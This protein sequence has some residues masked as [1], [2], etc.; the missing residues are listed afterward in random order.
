MGIVFP[1]EVKTEIRRLISSLPQSLKVVSSGYLVD[2]IYDLEGYPSLKQY[3]DRPKPS[4]KRFMALLLK[5][6][7]VPLDKDPGKGTPTT[8]RIREMIV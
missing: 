7:Q 4:Q 8:W 6:L 5:E 1:P 2:H 3:F